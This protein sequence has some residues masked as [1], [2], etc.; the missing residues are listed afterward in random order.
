MS[1]KKY[2]FNK[3]AAIRGA[4][5]RTFA[6]SPLVIEKVQESRREEPRFNK[7]GSRHKKN[8]VKRQCE[9]CS[10]WVKSGDINIDHITPVISVEEG[11]TDWNTFV[12]RLFCDKEN[13]Q[14]ICSNCHDSKTQIERIGRLTLKYTKEL[15]EIESAISDK[16]PA[17]DDKAAIKQLNKYISK[18]KSIGLTAIANRATELK[19]KLINKKV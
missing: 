18:K 5:R 14:R 3:E 12:D 11:K 13:L 4:L 1:K 10:E 15:D 9:V 19:T 7:D 16:R 17:I 8:W 2:K 6:R